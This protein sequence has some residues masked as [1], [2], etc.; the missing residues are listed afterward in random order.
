VTATE[1]LECTLGAGAFLFHFHSFMNIVDMSCTKR[2]GIFF[3][4]HFSDRLDGEGRDTWIVDNINEHME[5]LASCLRSTSCLHAEECAHGGGLM[6]SGT[7]RITSQVPPSNAIRR[8]LTRPV[9][10]RWHVVRINKQRMS[11]NEWDFDFVTPISAALLH[12]GRQIPGS[13]KLRWP[14]LVDEHQVRSPTNFPLD[15]PLSAP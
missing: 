13:W 12:H 5:V 2:K 15:Q 14:P 10:R 1:D 3:R 9:L 4:L 7:C 8:S 11:L 6:C